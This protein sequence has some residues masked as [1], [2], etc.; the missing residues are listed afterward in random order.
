MAAVARILLDAARLAGVLAEVAAVRF[1]LHRRDDG[2]LARVMGAFDRSFHAA[3]LPAAG[4]F[5]GLLRTSKNVNCAA[6]L[7][8]C[9]HGGE[10]CAFNV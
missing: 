3:F 10:G 4:L 5:Y 9:I 2:A 1:R 7:E 6:P 8:A